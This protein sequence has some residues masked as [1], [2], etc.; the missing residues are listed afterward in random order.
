MYLLG[1]YLSYQ[2]VQV[3]IGESELPCSGTLVPIGLS[4]RVLEQC[5]GKLAAR[6][7]SVQLRLI[8]LVS[9]REGRKKARR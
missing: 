7:Y 4:G 3:T 5:L 8:D 9:R 1:A 6:V 2:A